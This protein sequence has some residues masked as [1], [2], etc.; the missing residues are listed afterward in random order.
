[1][2]EIVASYLL[3]DNKGNFHKKAEGI[4]LGLTVGSWTDL[5]LLDQ[6]QLVQFLQASYVLEA[7]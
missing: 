1:M 4:A 2:S 7:T 6:Q 3:H 5:P